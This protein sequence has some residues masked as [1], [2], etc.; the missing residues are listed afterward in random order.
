MTNVI[1]GWFV[2]PCFVIVAMVCVLMVVHAIFV[3]VASGEIE[4]HVFALLT[5]KEE[6][7]RRTRGWL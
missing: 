7:F 2:A 3:S 5:G 6:R 4:L 1:E